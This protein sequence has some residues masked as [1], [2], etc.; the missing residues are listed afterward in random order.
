MIN[1]LSPDQVVTHWGSIE[2]LLQRVLSRFDYGSD[3]EHILIDVVNGR[4]QIWEIAD[5][6]AIAVTEVCNLPK[7]SVLD[8]PLVSGDNM[9]TWLEPLLDQLTEYAKASGCRYIDGFGRKGWTRKLEKYG[10]KPYS[11]DVRLKV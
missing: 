2:P 1:L 4:R 3:A 7:F 8:I 9:E 5:F 10:F 11:Y 6:S